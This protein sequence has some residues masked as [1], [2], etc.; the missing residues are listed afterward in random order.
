MDLL[1][2]GAAAAVIK[3]FLHSLA[4]AGIFVPPVTLKGVSLCRA[5]HN[6]TYADNLIMPGML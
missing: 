3:D 5:R 4:G 6:D 1:A 2:Y